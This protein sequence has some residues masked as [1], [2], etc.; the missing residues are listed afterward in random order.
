MLILVMINIEKQAGAELCQAQ[1][2]LEVIVDVVEEAWSQ[3][4]SCMLHSRGDSVLLRWLG[5]W[6]A[7]DVENIATQL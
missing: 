2:K 7:G 6:V 4:W 3:R 1:I 5:G